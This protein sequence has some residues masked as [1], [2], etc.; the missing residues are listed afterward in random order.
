MKSKF[1]G[2]ILVMIMYRWDILYYTWFLFI[3][4]GHSTNTIAND[5]LIESFM[6]IGIGYHCL[7]VYICYFLLHI[8]Y[9]SVIYTCIFNQNF[10]FF[11]TNIVSILPPL[12][13]KIYWKYILRNK[14]WNK[15]TH[16]VY[17]FTN[18]MK[19]SGHHH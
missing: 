7:H 15:N 4:Y 2:S 11:R 17:K 13:K 18:P 19:N 6:I 3:T 10:L 8:Q 12:S 1:K 14:I 9:T 5:R 16:R